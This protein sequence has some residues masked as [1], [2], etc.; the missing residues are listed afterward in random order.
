MTEHSSDHEIS[1]AADKEVDA[2]TNKKPLDNIEEDILE[3]SDKMPETPNLESSETED[4][5]V[6]DK[7]NN[8]SSK[9]NLKVTAEHD[10]EEVRE[11]ADEEDNSSVKGDKTE[12]TTSQEKVSCS[13]E[14]NS[15]DTKEKEESVSSSDVKDSD[16]EKSNLTSK[17]D[18]EA[19]SA[20]L[21]SSKCLLKRNRDDLD[22][23]YDSCDDEEEPI[24]KKSNVGEVTPKLVSK[25]NSSE[26]LAS[27][28]SSKLLL[29]R[30]FEKVEVANREE[31]TDAPESKKSNLTVS[32]HTE[33]DAQ[34][35]PEETRKADSSKN[36]KTPSQDNNTPSEDIKTPE[37]VSPPRAKNPALKTL[38]FTKSPC[39]QI[40][41]DS[42]SLSIPSPARDPERTV[43][44]Q[45]VKEEVRQKIGA[46]ELAGQRQLER[47]RLNKMLAIFDDQ[48]IVK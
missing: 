17:L 30:G 5:E 29:K 10:V 36:N 46:K 23:D 8:T 20:S 35:H 43:K 22:D 2:V 31:K 4:T 33:G 39:Q 6:D 38:N 44:E 15:K 11:T 28:S 25:L 26:L 19:L 9:T 34:E 47:K 48:K 14:S 37:K 27:M 45:P 12:D 32:H 21:S 40:P 13:E 7:T 18:A 24:S 16:H 42:V 41:A 3:A 1:A